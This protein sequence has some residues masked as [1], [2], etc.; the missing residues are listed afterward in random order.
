MLAF[1]VLVSYKP[2]SYKKET[3]ILQPIN[4][5]AWPE[6]TAAASVYLCNSTCAS[7]VQFRKLEYLLTL[8][9]IS[10]FNPLEIVMS[11]NS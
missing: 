4:Q 8:Q 7:I 6:E 10:Y 11:S 1:L 5:I 9:H 2:V 3:C